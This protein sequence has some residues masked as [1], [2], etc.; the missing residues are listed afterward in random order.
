MWA[1]ASEYFNLEFKIKITL[2]AIFGPESKYHGDY[3]NQAIPIIPEILYQQGLNIGSTIQKREFV[4]GLDLKKWFL[5][6]T[7]HASFFFAIFDLLH[8]TLS[9]LNPLVPEA[10]KS[11]RRDRLASFQTARRQPMIN[12]RIFIFCIP[13]TNGLMQHG[14]RMISIKISR[15]RRALDVF[16]S[17]LFGK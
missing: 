9:C 2:L 14:S 15:Q 8:M 3:P 5:G 16:H 6:N 12:W 7:S 10:H 1:G 11:E 17:C 4:S 13:G